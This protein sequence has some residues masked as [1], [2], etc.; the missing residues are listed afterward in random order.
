MKNGGGL[1]TAGGRV[2]RAD[3]RCDLSD[4][5]AKSGES[6]GEAE[7]LRGDFTAGYDAAC[8]RMRERSVGLR[9]KLR[10]G[11]CVALRR[12]TLYVWVMD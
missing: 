4:R 11:R 12:R 6:F 7:V 8:G 5:C 1:L 2:S 9:I 10:T 3:A